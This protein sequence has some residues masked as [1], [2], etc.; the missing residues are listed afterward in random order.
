MVV[1][2]MNADCGSCKLPAGVMPAGLRRKTSPKSVTLGSP[3]WKAPVWVGS[4]PTGGRQGG[5]DG[6]T[7][8]VETGIQCCGIETG[9]FVKLSSAV[10]LKLTYALANGGSS[11]K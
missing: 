3:A 7:A 6:F 4:H 1:S 8:C 10:G 5:K 2:G 9:V 11:G